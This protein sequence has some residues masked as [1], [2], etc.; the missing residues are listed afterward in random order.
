MHRAGGRP[1]AALHHVSEDVPL[2]HGLGALL[3]RR[4]VVHHHLQIG[5]NKTF[6]SF[7]SDARRLYYKYFYSH[8][9]TAPFTKY[10][11]LFEYQLLLTD[12]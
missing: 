6:L 3:C 5:I 9:G 10:K 4:E 12:I 2:H 1:V 8:N 11:Q 7:V